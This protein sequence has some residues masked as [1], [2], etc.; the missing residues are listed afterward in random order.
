MA[1]V[2]GFV[3]VLKNE[4]FTDGVFKIGYTDVNPYKRAA[5]L[6]SATGV[7]GDFD[8]AAFYIFSDPYNAEQVIHKLLSGFRI[9]NKKFFFCRFTDIH[10]LITGTDWEKINDTFSGDRG[11]MLVIDYYGSVILGCGEN[12]LAI[13]S[14][15]ESRSR[16]AGDHLL[17][18][19]GEAA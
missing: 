14:Y 1:K 9:A 5:E 8:V 19:D 12:E 3:Y 18:V 16:E 6:S 2:P 10:A 7:P 15:M 13:D 4:Y 11:E 17:I